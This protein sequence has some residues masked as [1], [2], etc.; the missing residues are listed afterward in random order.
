MYKKERAKV[1]NVKIF[2]LVQTFGPN[3]E[4]L[5]ASHRHVMVDSV[6]GSLRGSE[7]VSPCSP[8]SPDPSHCG[9]GRKETSPMDITRALSSLQT[10]AGTRGLSPP[11]VGYHHHISGHASPG[12]T[13]TSPPLFRNSSQHRRRAGKRNHHSGGGASQVGIGMDFQDPD[14]LISVDVLIVSPNC[15]SMMESQEKQEEME[16][17]FFFLKEVCLWRKCL[18]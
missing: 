8:G 17:S 16:G 18:L 13:V 4:L 1:H 3:F 14:A 9:S 12:S 6:S 7:P 11:S 2:Y 5:V 10:S 15:P